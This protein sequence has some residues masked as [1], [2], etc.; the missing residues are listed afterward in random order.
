MPIPSSHICRRRRRILR[1]WRRVRL[2][3]CG[4][5]TLLC[6]VYVLFCVCGVCTVLRVWCMSCSVY[7]VYVL[8]YVCG[9]CTV[10]CVVRKYYPMWSMCCSACVVQVRT[11]LC[12]YGPVLCKYELS[13][14]MP[15]PLC[16]FYALLFVGYIPSTFL[17]LCV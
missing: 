17:Y 1:R 5:C 9:V 10:P 11:V 14:V 6:V 7:V 3:P 12:K 2:I 16:A 15:M 13:F 4:V 8:F